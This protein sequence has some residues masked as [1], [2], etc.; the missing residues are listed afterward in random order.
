MIC[1]KITEIFTSING[2]GRRAG[3]LAVFVRFA[4]CN[5]ECSYCDTKWANHNDTKYIVM[6]TQ[7]VYSHI[8]S[9]KINCVTVTGGEPLIQEGIFKLLECL[10]GDVSLS[11]EIETNGSA[12]ISGV[13]KL[14][15]NRP[16][17][18]MDYKLPS[19][20]SEK[21]MLPENLKK[22]EE[23]DTVKFVCGSQ[24]DL[25]R[26]YEVINRYDLINKCGVYLSP[27]FG[28]LEPVRIV[29]FMKEHNLNGVNLQLQMH[30]FIW[31][32]GERGV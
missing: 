2:E 25:E 9:E 11:V 30:K 4:G 28:R 20:G 5:L 22:L 24:E 13:L 6:D 27:V 16:L 32:P 17:I 3:Q 29:E 10:S 7:Q 18:T 8:K 19:S 23:K 14:G 26:A 31:E 1:Y 12:D 15:K 21:S